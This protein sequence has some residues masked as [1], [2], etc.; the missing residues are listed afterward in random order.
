MAVKGYK[1]KGK[2]LTTY[3]VSQFNELEPTRQYIPPTD[4]TADEEPPLNE[5]PDA[6]KSESDIRDEITGQ[7]KLF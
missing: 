1:A 4:D 5:D 6:G 2:R 3:E 7:M